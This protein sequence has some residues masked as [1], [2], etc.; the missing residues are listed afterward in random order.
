MSQQQVAYRLAEP[1]LQQ[2]AHQLQQLQHAMKASH[3]GIALLILSGTKRDTL[4]AVED[5][6]A[7]LV[8]FVTYP[9][10][11]A[12]QAAYDA[13]AIV[14]GCSSQAGKMTR[15]ARYRSRSKG[16][17]GASGDRALPSTTADA[18]SRMSVRQDASWRG[19]WYHIKSALIRCSM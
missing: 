12:A 19:L 3:A 18:A 15:A 14:L 2:E 9:V 6:L 13:V 11:F 17:S 1:R 10:F 7:G 8:A 5:D 4:Q 16:R